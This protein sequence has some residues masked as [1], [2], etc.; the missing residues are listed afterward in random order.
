[1]AEENEA[2]K[3]YI[4]LGQL[5]LFLAIKSVFFGIEA[6]SDSSLINQLV[7]LLSSHEEIH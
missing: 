4:S 2:H 6:F 3:V 7:T 5:Q 1:M